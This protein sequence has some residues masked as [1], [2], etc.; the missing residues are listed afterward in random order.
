MVI[1]DATEIDGEWYYKEQFDPE[2]AD[3]NAYVPTIEL[4]FDDGDVSPD[5]DDA[6]IDEKIFQR[7]VR[8]LNENR[9]FN[10]DWRESECDRAHFDLVCTSVNFI[11][12]TYPISTTR[13][14][15]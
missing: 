6:E 1:Y 4:K 15:G 3:M 9:V 13:R 10:M 12:E 8:Y 14:C 5:D 2:T 11:F 7:V